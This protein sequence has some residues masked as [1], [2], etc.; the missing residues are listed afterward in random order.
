MNSA[1]EAL[2]KMEDI[3]TIKARDIFNNSI[4][5]EIKWKSDYDEE[6]AHEE[7]DNLNIDYKQKKTPTLDNVKHNIYRYI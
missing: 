5:K 3:Y 7:N 4:K 6:E 1:K 2:N